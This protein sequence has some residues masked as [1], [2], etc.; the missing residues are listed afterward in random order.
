VCAPVAA[1]W[2][3]LPSLHQVLAALLMLFLTVLA[4]LQRMR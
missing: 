4:P 1:A 2:S 3:L